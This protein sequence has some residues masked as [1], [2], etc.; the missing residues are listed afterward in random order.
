MAIYE[1]TFSDEIV[2]PYCGHHQPYSYNQELLEKEG[3]SYVV[4]C[5]CGKKYTATCKVLIRFIG[6]PDCQLNEE[7]HDF[8]L[9]GHSY[10]CSKCNKRKP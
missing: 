6:I 3:D 7:A 4:K 2:C 5:I 1:P 9:N 8:I 10:F